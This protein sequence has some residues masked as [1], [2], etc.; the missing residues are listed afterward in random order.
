MKQRLWSWRWR[1]SPLR[2]GVDVAEGWLILAAVTL[3]AVGGLLAG[4]RTAGAVD[5]YLDRQRVERQRTP[6]VLL[7][8][9]KQPPRVDGTSEVH[10]ERT[11]AKVR[12]LDGDGR[13]HRAM[14]RVASDLKVGQTTQVWTDTSGR[15][16]LPAP[17]SGGQAAVQSAFTGA[18]AALGVVALVAVG[19]RL[20]QRRIDRA[21]ERWWAAEWA[22]VGPEW[23]RNDA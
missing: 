21:R 16:I 2:R 6:A 12:W 18:S 4:V 22:R 15:R 1:E 8:N 19:C 5:D 13:P 14:T 23:R 9:P 11:R 20:G 7:Q 3:A 17:A 10:G